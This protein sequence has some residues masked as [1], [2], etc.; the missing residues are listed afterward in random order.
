MLTL[1]ALPSS[2]TMIS[3][4]Q[5]VVTSWLPEFL[6]VIYVVLGLTVVVGTILFIRKKFGGAIAKILGVR[7]GR[8]SMRRRY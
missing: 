6:P 1:F 5:S 7:G 2:S 4:S 3:E 8:R